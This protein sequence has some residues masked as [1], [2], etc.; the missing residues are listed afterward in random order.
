MKKLTLLLSALVLMLHG[1]AYAQNETATESKFPYGKMLKMSDNQLKEA[2]FKFNDEMN[3]WVLMKLNGL[4]QTVA[5]LGALNGSAANYTPHVND[6]KVI[7]QKGVTGV[8][9]IDVV[10]Y[11]SKI[12]H[13]ILT[14]ANDN[15]VDLL[16][17][18]SGNLTKTQFN[19]DN[20]SF[21]LNR[22]TVGQAAIVA[23]RG[24][25]SSRDQSYGVFSFTIYTDEKPYSK[26]LVKEAEKQA[27]RD[28]KG[29]KKQ[30]AGDFM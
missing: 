4:N 20:Y 21:A 15:G 13:E 9:S 16:E 5:I 12:Y 6:Y 26:W 24:D 19:Y 23:G 10:F 25:V 8:A 3:Q 22:E 27:K 18:T 7:I 29:K 2:K 17:T 14:F 28:A 1:G 11:D 30:S